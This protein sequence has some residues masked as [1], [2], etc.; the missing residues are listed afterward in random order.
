MGACIKPK[1]TLLCIAAVVIAAFLLPGFLFVSMFYP[2]IIETTEPTKS[3]VE[4]CKENM[5]LEKDLVVNPIGYR[6]KRD[7]ID[8]TAWF[9]FKTPEKDPAK[10][11]DTSF[12][13]IAHL[14]KESIDLLS[15]YESKWW[16]AKEDNLLQAK[17]D[18]PRQNFLYVGIQGTEEGSIVYLFWYET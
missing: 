6:L 15:E 4:F 11:F 16:H 17:F 8:L 3:Q 10:I 13:N 12:I 2:A 5:C 9:K 14:K 18:L 1:N 7:S